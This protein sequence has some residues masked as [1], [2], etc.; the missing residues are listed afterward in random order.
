MRKTLKINPQDN[1]MVALQDL[2]AGEKIQ[3]GDAEIMVKTAVTAGH[4]VAIKDISEGENIIK[5]GFPIGTAANDIAAGDWI[6]THNMPKPD[7]VICS[8]IRMNR[9]SGH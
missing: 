7:S 3:I 9:I 1:V 4:K 5:Y 6:H 8:T 2:H